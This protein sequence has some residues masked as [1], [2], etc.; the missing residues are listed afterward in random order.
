MLLGYFM[1]NVLLAWA[2]LQQPY[3][4]KTLS[5]PPPKNP[6]NWVHSVIFK[7]Q[8]KIQLTHSSYKV[9]SFLD[10]QPFMHGFQSVSNYLD[11]LWTDIQNPYHFLY[12]FIPF[13]HIQINPTVNDSHIEKFLKSSACKQCPFSCQAKMKFARF[14]WEIHYIIKIFGAIYKKFLTAIDHIDYHPSQMQSNITRAKRSVAYDT[15]GQYHSPTESLTPSEEEFLDAFMKALIKINPAL[16]SN[17]SCMKRVGVFT[18]ILGW[19]V[20]SNAR[21]IAKIKDNIHTLQK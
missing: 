17:L 3:L 20:Y 9:T 21:N 6:N 18:W 15:Y 4:S 12:L 19:G 13:A 8:P 16:H 7:P 5:S 1:C 11:N 10:F 2:M 14:K